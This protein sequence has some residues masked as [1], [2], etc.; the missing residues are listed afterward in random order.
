MTWL[1]RT[2]FSGVLAVSLLAVTVTGRVTL[3]ESRQR[4]ARSLPDYSR[5]RG[6]AGAAGRARGAYCSADKD[7]EQ[8]LTFLRLLGERN[9]ILGL[10]GTT[11]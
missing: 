3:R 7:A 1:L 9:G 2:Y 10:T 4:S 11:T 5:V 6:V 8:I